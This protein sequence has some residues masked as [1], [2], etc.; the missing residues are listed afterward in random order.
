[1]CRGSETIQPGNL[2]RKASSVPIAGRGA[3]GQG[4]GGQTT[5]ASARTLTRCSR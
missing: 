3:D 4:L 1:M 5:M 2:R